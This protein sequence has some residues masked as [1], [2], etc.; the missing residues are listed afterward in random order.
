M[1]GFKSPKVCG[2]A[3]NLIAV[4][5]NVATAVLVV[6]SMEIGVFPRG[7]ESPCLWGA[8]R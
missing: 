6:V 2:A 7:W 5:A 3:E 4:G 8:R 1:L